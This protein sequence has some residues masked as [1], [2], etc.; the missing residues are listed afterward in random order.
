M[1]QCRSALDVLD[2][3]ASL[4]IFSLKQRTFFINL[5]SAVWVNPRHTNA[6]QK[7]GGEQVKLCPF[8]ILR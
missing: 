3:N 1:C 5:D 8:T 6:E 4:F 7:P 2:L